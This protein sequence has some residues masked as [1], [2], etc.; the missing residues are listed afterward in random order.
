MAG[1]SGALLLTTM[2]IPTTEEINFVDASLQGSVTVSDIFNVSR[3]LFGSDAAKRFAANGVDFAD[4]SAGFSFGLLVAQA[5][6]LKE[7]DPAVH[8]WFLDV[9]EPEYFRNFEAI[10]A[11][12]ATGDPALLSAA[13]FRREYLLNLIAEY[14]QAQAKFEEFHTAKEAH[15]G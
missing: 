10:V 3:N 13:E 2:R 1:I 9:Y 14:A 7:M 4:F 8:R 11:A 6:A 12:R 15:I 5:F